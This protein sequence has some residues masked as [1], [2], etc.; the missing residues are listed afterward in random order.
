VHFEVL[1]EDKSGSIVV[2][3]ILEAIL[4]PHG[5]HSCKVHSYKGLGPIPRDLSTSSDP[6][7]RLL[8]DRL[9]KILRGYG[10]SLS[11]LDA[12]VLVVVDVDSRDC[13]LLKQELVSLRERC[14]PRPETLFRLAVEV[15]LATI[16]SA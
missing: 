16:K 2:E 8:L 10:N 13:R 3:H 4:G 9:P 7:K 12:S 11:D 1:V 14:H 5:E 15:L 6:Q